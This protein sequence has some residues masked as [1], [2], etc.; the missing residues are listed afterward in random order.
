MRIYLAGYSI[1]PLKH[2][3]AD[4][5]VR[6]LVSFWDLLK[7]NTKWE[8][9]MP[10]TD[11]FLD[12]GAFSA[13]SRGVE[14]NLDDY[15]R[16][17][18]GVK[19]R[20]T[21]YANLDVIGKAQETWDN[22]MEMERQGLNPM[23]VFHVGKEDMS[24]LKKIAGRYEHFG[25]GGMG[26]KDITTT[27]ITKALDEIFTYLADKKGNIK[28]RIHGFAVTTMSLMLRYPFHSVDS[29][30]WV[31]QGRFGGIFILLEDGRMV[32]VSVS[33]KSPDQEKAGAH[34]RTLSK[35]EQ[36][37]V[38]GRIQSNGFTVREAEERYQARD[39]INIRFFQE[40]ERKWKPVKFNPHIVQGSF[41]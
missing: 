24:W 35:L 17:V 3:A 26:G 25:L 34:Y 4:W 6:D 1:L 5:D 16:F 39:I 28:H 19:E 7:K 14:I 31:L 30:A 32:A 12:S 10:R 21:V 8:R 27:R 20:V 37:E 15:I 29:T 23:P 41:F 36:K 38:E 9:L 13:W 22:Q 40:L 33:E 2:P 11:I 18:D